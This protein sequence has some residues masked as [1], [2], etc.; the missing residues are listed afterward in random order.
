M[1]KKMMNEETRKTRKH[2][3]SKTNKPTFEPDYGVTKKDLEN[4][5]DKID[6]RMQ[7]MATKLDLAQLE[8][9]ML[10]TMASK[11]EMRMLI[12]GL[13]LLIIVGL[14]LLTYLGYGHK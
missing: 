2:P 14:G 9:R 5:A 10:N 12:G 6:L 11:T 8:I 4:L 13:Y 7:S 1:R 3:S